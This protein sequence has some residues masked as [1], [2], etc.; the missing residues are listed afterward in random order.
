MAGQ[1]F[2]EMPVEFRSVYT[3]VN[4][5]TGEKL[6]AETDG[7]RGRM[8]YCEPDTGRPAEACPQWWVVANGRIY[9][10][11]TPAE[12]YTLRVL[13]KM[14][15]PEVS[16]DTLD[17]EPIIP[18]EYHMA[19]AFAAAVS[20]LR[21]HPEVSGQLGEGSVKA[22]LEQQVEMALVDKPL[23]K[24]EENLDKRS[25]FALGFRFGRSW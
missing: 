2:I 7:M 5:Q 12:M 20:F 1:E 25:R 4:S 24:Q 22:D 21:L 16:R 17:D 8:R 19:L 14:R 23:P 13:G 6:M 15:P 9:L 3:I 10:R 11:P 18:P